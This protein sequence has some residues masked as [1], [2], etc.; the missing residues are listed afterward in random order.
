MAN[1]D[2]LSPGILLVVVMAA[3]GFALARWEVVRHYGSS[4]LTLA[5]V[6]GAALGNLVPRF[7]HG[8]FRPGLQFAQRR[9]LRAGVALYGF[10]LSFQQIVEVGSTGIVVDVVMVTST[11]A[12]GWLIGRRWLGMDRETVLL[13]AAGSA[14]C[15]AAAVVATVPMLRCSNDESAA[16]K[17]TVAV[18]SVVLFGSLA[19]LVYPLLFRWF[20]GLFDFGVYVGS[21]VHE[22][23][24]V[25]AIGSAIGDGVARSAVIVKMIRVMLLVPFLL[26]VAQSSGRGEGGA[27]L[28]VPWFAVMFVVLAIVNSLRLLPPELVDMLRL[29]GILLLTA[30]M[31][32]LGVD[33]NLSR[34]RK[35]GIRPLMLGGGLFVHLLV[36]GGVVN[37]LAA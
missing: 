10:N 25:V 18:A 32:A 17:S 29:M 33:T 5:L 23:A 12:V 4:S 35:A 7:G 1:E 31:A 36:T 8:A 28:Q 19:M 6:C 14:I 2:R 27:K 34:V 30:A 20:G 22:V 26:L 9:L 15:G 24:Q 37:W 11:L 13:T 21:T 3:A 16:E